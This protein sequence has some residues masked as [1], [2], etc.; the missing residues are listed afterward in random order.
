M[1]YSTFVMYCETFPQS[2][3][4]K[5]IKNKIIKNKTSSISPRIKVK[6]VE[7]GIKQF[8][9]QF[10]LRGPW[11]PLR[12]QN[13]TRRFRLGLSM[14][15]HPNPYIQVTP[16][17]F[18][19][20]FS[21]FGHAE[22]VY[23]RKRASPL[24][25]AGWLS[26][27][28]AQCS[29]PSFPISQCRRTSRGR[30]LMGR[31]LILIF[32]KLADALLLA[33]FA[34]SAPVRIRRDARVRTDS[35]RFDLTQTETLVLEKRLS[36]SLSLPSSS[37]LSPLQTQRACTAVS[38]HAKLTR[39]NSA[40]PLALPAPLPLWLETS[41]TGPSC[42]FSLSFFY[43]DNLKSKPRACWS[44]ACTNPAPRFQLNAE[45]LLAQP[46]SS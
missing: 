35:L 36:L 11:M 30:E 38:Q 29:S 26:L 33:R 32:P 8:C 20:L 45:T 43:F 1:T 39:A 23:V 24:P 13:G 4:R 46:S 5:I 7:K 3:G 42:F 17:F 40:L 12:P 18:P 10:C 19:F 21:P 14:R 22:F 27:A 28:H 2:L 34:V 41:T 25:S 44:P 6:Y 31:L 9:S 15:P 37:S 16:N